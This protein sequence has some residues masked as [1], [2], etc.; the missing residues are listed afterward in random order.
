MRVRDAALASVRPR[1]TPFIDHA[2]RQSR[3]HLVVDSTCP[4]HEKKEGGGELGSIDVV[5]TLGKR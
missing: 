2:R 4:N 1:T 3:P 5:V